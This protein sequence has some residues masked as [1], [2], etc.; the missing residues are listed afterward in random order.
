VLPGAAAIWWVPGPDEDPVVLHRPDAGRRTALF[1]VAEV[2]GSPAALYKI[3]QQ[4]EHIIEEILVTHLLESGEVRR[5]GAVGGLEVSADCASWAVDR[6]VIASHAETNNWF[7][8]IGIDGEPIDL[9][10]A[11][12][13]AL[14]A[15]E[16]TY[17]T[18]CAALRESDGAAAVVLRSWEGPN[19]LVIVDM[20][21]GT[22]TH[23]VAIDEA[24]LAE[25][26]SAEMLPDV[27]RWETRVDLV[28][29]AVLVSNLTPGFEYQFM[30]HLDDGS[31]EEIPIPGVA[32]WVR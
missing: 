24:L 27:G 5:V 16:E 26:A 1:G 14:R 20:T 23:R 13:P 15:T 17:A 2:D 4:G 28:G 7:D 21:T 32:S 11:L 3:E 8:L 9:S 19:E 29:D 25:L 12:P 10:F 22:E 31:R 30:V 18:T 6:F